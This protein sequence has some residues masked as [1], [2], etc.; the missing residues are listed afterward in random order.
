MLTHISQQLPRE[1][2][3]LP[4]FSPHRRPHIPHRLVGHGCWL[5]CIEDPVR[6]WLHQ[7]QQGERQGQTDRPYVLV[8]PARS[9]R[10]GRIHRRQDAFVNQTNP[11]VVIGFQ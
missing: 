8:V 7:P 1:R 3:Q 4:R 9:V 11:K 10:Y 6:R 2:D 5:D